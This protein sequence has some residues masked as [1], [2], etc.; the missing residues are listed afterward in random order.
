LRAAFAVADVN[1]DESA[2][3][4]A[5][6]NPAGKRDGLPDVCRAQ[7]VAMMRAF[8]LK[9]RQSEYASWPETRHFSK[10]FLAAINSRL[11]LRVQLN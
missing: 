8:H 6:V 3:V 2:Q 7:F 9:N 10:S 5:G 4:A 1:E 11:A